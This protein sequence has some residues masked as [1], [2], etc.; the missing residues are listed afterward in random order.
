MYEVITITSKRVLVEKFRDERNA[1]GYFKVA[2]F[3][4]PEEEQVRKVYLTHEN[5]I[6]VEQVYN[7]K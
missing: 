3:G 5:Y 6:I 1:M 2:R 7:N 4:F